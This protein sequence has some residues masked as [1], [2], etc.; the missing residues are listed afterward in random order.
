MQFR[1]V[2]VNIN[3][4]KSKCSALRANQINFMFV[5][6][7][8]ILEKKGGTLSRVFEKGDWMKRGDYL[9]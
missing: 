5:Y 4:R 2:S 7:M 9:L 6:N 8:G 3:L 1:A